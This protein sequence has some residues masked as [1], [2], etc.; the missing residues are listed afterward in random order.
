MRDLQTRPGSVIIITIIS[1]IVV[2]NVRGQLRLETLNMMAYDASS[3]QRLMWFNTTSCIPS[4]IVSAHHATDGWMN[5]RMDG[6]M[7]QR[8]R[9]ATSCAAHHRTHPCCSWSRRCDRAKCRP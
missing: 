6:W 7:N 2:A 5:E 1:I 4:T 8:E 9:F 3:G